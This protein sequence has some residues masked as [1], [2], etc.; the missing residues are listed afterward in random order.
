MAGSS[1][2]QSSDLGHATPPLYTS[3][4]LALTWGFV[5]SFIHS[6]KDYGLTTLNVT[7]KE[8]KDRGRIKTLMH[9]KCLP[10]A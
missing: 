8:P 1:N 2:S 6:F 7:R 9:A 10:M 3:P 4:G 5:H